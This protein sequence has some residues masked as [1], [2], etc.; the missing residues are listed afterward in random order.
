MQESGFYTPS[1]LAVLARR[2][3][4]DAGLTQREVGDS[5]GVSQAAV[6]S[7]EKGEQRYMRLVSLM[8]QTLGDYEIDETPRYH[9]K[10]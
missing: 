4:R 2:L 3:R 10:S 8:L 9:I 5:L 1:E 6:S 7:A